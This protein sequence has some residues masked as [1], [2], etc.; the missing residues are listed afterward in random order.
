MD[1]RDV[2]V[3]TR[4]PDG[5]RE[6]RRAAH[7]EVVATQVERREVSRIDGQ[8]GPEA[9]LVEVP[10]ERPRMDACGIDPVAEALRVEEGRVDA[11]RRKKLGE[12]DRD[13]L[14]AA[15]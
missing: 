13:A 5:L 7:D 3:A 12:L 8:Q 14:G 4:R 15:V 6:R 2:D 11:C 9:L 1:V 10:G